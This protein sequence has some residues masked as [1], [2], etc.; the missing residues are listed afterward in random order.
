MPDRI[1]HDILAEIVGIA[2]DAIICMDD[3]QR[4][5]FFNS[6]A[7]QIFGWSSEEVLGQRIEMLLPERHRASHAS[8]VAD[9]RRSKVTARRMGERRE[10]AGV[11]KSGEE[12]P[13]EAAISQVHQGDSAIY[14][15]V[16]RDV[17]VRKKFEQRQAFLAS[18]GEKLASSFGSGEV[19]ENV[20]RLA[21]PV[22]ADGCILE[23]RIDDGYRAGAVAHLDPEIDELLR[24]ITS[25]GVR[26]PLPA[27]P[28]SEILRTQAPILLR[29]N[30]AAR[31]IEASANTFY[32]AGLKMMNPETALF[33]PLIARGHL[34]GVLSL[35]RTRRGFDADELAFAEDLARLA[36]LALD[37]SRLL[38]TVRASLRSRE[39]IVGVVSHDLRNP[40]A[41][42][43][44]LSR[45]VLSE[46]NHGG[47]GQTGNI[48]LIAKAAE[49]MDGL[50]RDL[51]LVSR[52]DAGKL[53]IHQEPTDPSSLL[54]G[55][56]QT[57]LPLVEEKAI[58]LDM[59]LEVGLPK[60]LADR[61]RIQQTIS[62]LVGNAIKFTPSGGKIIVR[63]QSGDEEVI[64]SVID[65]G[66]G[67]SA[68]Q[69]PNVFDRYWQS[70]RTDRE[71]AGLGLAIAK[72]I[73]E[74]HGGR[75]WIDSTPGQGT[76]ASFTLPVTRS[77]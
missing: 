27:H 8:H 61:E 26:H 52:L 66:T 19:L 33:L 31:I 73:V 25:A 35:F 53:T 67:I 77:D 20:A 17:S 40:V 63:T 3:L 29:S 2:A 15:V 51:L 18:A 11:R 43:K 60:V 4:I 14:A 50:I 68:E 9:F 12:F 21:V 30:A 47:T 70:S 49:Q 54:T 55:S 75:I 45:A 48:L 38:D 34:I 22:I 58:K 74:G 5:T 13:A 62:N 7:E 46:M 71:G 64:V 16:L 32:V 28:L 76:T 57:L 56:L 44:M 72:G 23:N 65:N 59:Q 69:L 1:T 41:A 24:R 10:I 42:V 6:G 39:E 36:A 37:N